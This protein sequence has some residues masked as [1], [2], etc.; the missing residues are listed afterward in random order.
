MYSTMP[1]GKLP[2]PAA[3]PGCRSGDAQY[4][5]DELG[6][7]TH[8]VVERARQR[9]QTL[10]ARGQQPRSFEFGFDRAQR[11]FALRLQR[12]QLPAPQV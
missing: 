7:V 8:L 3:A 10:D 9:L 2:P 4:G 11:G 5:P 12:S 1:R 6:D